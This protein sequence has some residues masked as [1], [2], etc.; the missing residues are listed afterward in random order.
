MLRLTQTAIGPISV[1]AGSSVAVPLVEAYNAGD[2]SLSLSAQSS[3][4]WLTA[5]IGAQAPCK[6]TTLAANCIPIQIQ[7]NAAGLANSATP[8]TGIVTITSPNAIDAP[9]TITVTAAVGGSIPSSLTVY[10]APGGSQDVPFTTNSMVSTQAK[11]SDGGAW[12]TVALQGTGSF[13]FV[14]PYDI[15]I[16]P[17]ASQT[18]GSYTGTIT[19]SGST[20]AG[21]N[22]T[23]AVTMQVTSQPIAQASAGQESF[24]LAQGAAPVTIPIAVANKGQGTLTIQSAS[25]T[26]QGV[27]ASVVS[28]GVSAVF[29][30]GSLAPGTYT[31]SISVT[32]N[33]ANSP[34]TIPVS[35]TVEAKGAPSLPFGGVVDNAIFGAGDPLAPGDIAALFGDQLLFQATAF[36]TQVPLPTTLGTTQVLVNGTPAP[37]FF[38][39]YGQIDFEIPANT[40]TGNAQVQV[41]RDGQTSNA[42]SVAIAARAPRLLQA[43]LTTASTG[44]ALTIY[45]IGLGQTVDTVASGAA[46][47]SSPLPLLISTPTI[48]FG[49]FVAVSA[50]PLYAGLSPGGVGLY[51]INVTVPPGLPK[52]AVDIRAMF[53]DGTVSNPVQVTIQ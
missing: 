35:F 41:V 25:S 51:Q 28:G 39:S 27:T 6:T 49:D 44:A 15:H 42:I 7:L 4:T 14:L 31:G 11:T 10:V 38:A 30:P 9:Q 13:R 20:F 43:G 16:A 46:S 5:V 23:I 26:A 17:L 19:T 24:T 47:P 18:S 34:L 3:V 1:A 48:F 12:L 52:G 37:L 45:A 21:D 36:A 33:A 8:L 2:G 40:A 32:S 50:T 22:K 53:A 29:D